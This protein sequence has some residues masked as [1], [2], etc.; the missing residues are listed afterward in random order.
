MQR[1][2]I[3]KGT[4]QVCKQEKNLSELVPPY[5]ISKSVLSVIQHDNPDWSMDGFICYND[6]N[7]YRNN[8]L[9]EIL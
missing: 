7:H 5:L 1:K 6:L 2:V 3:P 4:C 9:N 8:H